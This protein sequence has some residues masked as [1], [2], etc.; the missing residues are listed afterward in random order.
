MPHLGYINKHE[1]LDLLS[2]EKRACAAKYSTLIRNPERGNGPEISSLAKSRL[3]K[4]VVN[5]AVEAYRVGRVSEADL[6]TYAELIEKDEDELIEIAKRAAE[7][8]KRGNE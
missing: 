8:V 5:L 3:D 1:R 4:T 2:T 7:P 6:R